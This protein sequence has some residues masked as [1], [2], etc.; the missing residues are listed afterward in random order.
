MIIFLFLCENIY[1]VAR[2][3]RLNEMFPMSTH[4]ICFLAEIRK[5]KLQIPILFGA[6]YQLSSKKGLTINLTCFEDPD[7]PAYPHSL[8]EIWLYHL[9]AKAC[10]VTKFSN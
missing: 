5:I 7:Q 1:C 8:D 9:H 4:N 2:L 6:I 10:G 3:K